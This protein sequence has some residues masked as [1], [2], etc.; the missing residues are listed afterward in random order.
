MTFVKLFLYHCYLKSST[1]FHIYRWEIGIFIHS[2]GNS[3][4]ENKFLTTS[5]EEMTT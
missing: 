4:D 1:T 3:K 2:V 5:F